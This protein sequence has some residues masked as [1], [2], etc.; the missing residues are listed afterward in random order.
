[1]DCFPFF[2]IDN[3]ELFKL[4]QSDCSENNKFYD[5]HN[6]YDPC[7]FYDDYYYNYDYDNKNNYNGDDEEECIV[8]KGKGPCQC[9]GG[10]GDPNGRNAIRRKIFGI[11]LKK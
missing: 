5:Y 11:K 9:C 2:E 8:G 3:S 6:F 7:K 10:S 4:F 1:M